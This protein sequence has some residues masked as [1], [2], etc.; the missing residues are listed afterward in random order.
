MNAKNIILTGTPTP[1]F[2]HFYIRTQ[3]SSTLSY[4]IKFNAQFVN[5]IFTL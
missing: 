4:E 3:N 2:C 1:S 5:F